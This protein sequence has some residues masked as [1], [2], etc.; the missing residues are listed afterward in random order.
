MEPSALALFWAGVICFAI[1]MYT[2][3]DG[4]D[5][6]IGVLFGTTPDESLRVRMMDTIAPF[7]D[8]NETWLVMTGAS[9]FAAFPDVYAVF[10]SAFYLPVLLLLL[11]LIFRGVAFEF[12]FRSVR[13]RPVWDY[14]FFLGSTLAAFMQGAAVGGWVRGIPVTDG[15]YAGGPFGWLHPFAM[16]TG[17][18]LVLGYALLGASWLV[19]KGSGQIRDWASRRIRPLAA[20]VLIVL[21]LAFAYT[22]SSSTVARSGLQGRPWGYLFPVIALVAIAA[23]LFD[24]RVRRDK[25]PF[26]LTI[27]FF[28]A[29]FLALAVMFW[30]FMIPYTITVASA[31][32]PD[33]SL[34]FLFYAGVVV[35]PVI[36]A[37]SVGVYWIFRGKIHKAD[38]SL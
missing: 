8:G 25:L 16:L 7:W 38:I 30:P 5:L 11:S 23:I 29:S 37:Y 2:T 34:R 32:A 18:G 22:F 13:M 4:F 36:L 12:R 27:V 6:G 26:V 31:A 9:L 19:L 35:L 3:L 14:G 10:C 33:Q 1:V 17:I 28:F 15:H 20:S 24:A 21:L